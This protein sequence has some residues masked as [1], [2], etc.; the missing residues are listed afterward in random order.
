MKNTDRN[1]AFNIAYLALGYI[2]QVGV[3][4]NISRTFPGVDRNAMMRK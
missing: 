4:M 2:S 1:A 3:T